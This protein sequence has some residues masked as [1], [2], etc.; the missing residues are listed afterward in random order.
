MT[1]A[2]TIHRSSMSAL[3]FI[4][5][6]R[7]LVVSCLIAAITCVAPALAQQGP[8]QF[9]WASGF[10]QGT[11]EAMIRTA[12]D[13]YVAFACPAGQM[14][15]APSISVQ[16]RGR[17]PR[18]QTTLQIV[19]DGRNYPLGLNDGFSLGR[20][21][22]SEASII[23]AAHALVR[24]NARTFFAEIPEIGWRQQFSLANVRDALGARAGRTI[25]D[26]CLR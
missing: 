15:P 5:P 17:T 3:R 12:D 6:A 14:D 7:M 10:A 20:G 16:V 25:V 26:G 19:V 24:S 4:T 22:A 13:S 18:G 2:N 9:R 8:V 11:V 21:R 23:N 1:V